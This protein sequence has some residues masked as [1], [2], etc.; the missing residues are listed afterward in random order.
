[1]SEAN[2]N[3]TSFN[4]PFNSESV[5]QFQNDQQK[6]VM[7]T[8]IQLGT[9]KD[10][11]S[12][13]TVANLEVPQLKDTE[14]IDSESSSC[15]KMNWQK[16]AHKLREYNRKLLK[17]VF[18]L[19]QEIAEIDNKYNKYVE[20]SRTSDVLVAQQA[21][22][23]QTYQEQIASLN[24]QIDSK[25]TIV[26]EL[27]QQYESSQQQTAQ[28]ERECTLLQ[29]SYAQQACELAAK[30]KETKELQAKLHQ[31]QRYAMQYKAE[32]QRH[33]E[34]STVVSV[35]IPE[36]VAT[37]SQSY[38]NNRSIKP[39]STTKIP[40]PKISLPQTVKVEHK[41]LQ[42]SLKMSQ[43]AGEI[44]TWSASTVSQQQEKQSV[45]KSTQKH[46]PQSLAAVDLPTF[47]RS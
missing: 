32:L 6:E 46:K 18:R 17:K 15:Q 33:L 14:K 7:E 28:L 29:E 9:E 8:F 47:P 4:S 12:S 42:P 23:I 27:S 21:E 10:Y 35:S 37:Y 31:Q 26:S 13:D 1:M 30:V 5:E 40:E 44:A 45:V 39:W 36:P 43:K 24:Q 19:E 41:P 22:E 25:T 20:K 2:N 3:A 34:K 38:A 11:L 16:V